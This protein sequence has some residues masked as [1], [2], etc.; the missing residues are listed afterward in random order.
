[1]SEVVQ[2]AWAVLGLL[3]ADFPDRLVI[4]RGIKLIMSRQ[5]PNGEWLQESIEGVFSRNC[6]IAYPNFKFIFTVW[7]LGKFAKVYGNPQL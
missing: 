2:T 4:E 3:A 1:Q 7:A 5:Q 6:M